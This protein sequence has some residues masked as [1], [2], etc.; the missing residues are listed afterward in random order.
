MTS[1]INF[2]TRKKELGV[3]ANENENSLTIMLNLLENDFQVLY[4]MEKREYAKK[5]KLLISI[6]LFEL[7]NNMHKIIDEINNQ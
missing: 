4:Q 7:Q 2:F 6:A 1:F 3:T 5:E